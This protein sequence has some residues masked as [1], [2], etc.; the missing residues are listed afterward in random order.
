MRPEIDKTAF[1]QKCLVI[2]FR[3]HL[4][5]T[6]DSTSVEFFTPSCLFLASRQCPPNLRMIH[7][8]CSFPPEGV[9]EQEENKQRN[10]EELYQDL[11]PQL[12]P[13]HQE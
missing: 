1:R 9:F 8:L 13:A 11:T 5:P 12:V 7:M 10:F 2:D 4:S 6:S 3:R